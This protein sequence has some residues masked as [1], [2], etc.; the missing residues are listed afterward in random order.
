[1]FPES[2]AVRAHTPWESAPS[3]SG[4]AVK[5]HPVQA[6]AALHYTEVLLAFPVM[7]A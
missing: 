3:K 5:H 2:E 1:M 6:G 4:T 7:L